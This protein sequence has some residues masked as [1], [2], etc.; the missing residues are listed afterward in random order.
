MSKEHVVEMM[1]SCRI[2]MIPIDMTQR[3]GLAPKFVE[4]IS[5]VIDCPWVKL[6]SDIN[7]NAVMKAAQEGEWTIWLHPTDLVIV[8]KLPSHVVKNP[9]GLYQIPGVR[10][11]TPSE[12]IEW[13]CHD[14]QSPVL[15]Y[16]GKTK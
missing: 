10:F 14:H 15:R 1:K 12:A 9:A 7:I 5:L 2:A 11:E 3:G 6:A 16:L 8:L 13:L 4:S